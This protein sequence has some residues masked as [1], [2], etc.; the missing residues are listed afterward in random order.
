M[1]ATLILSSLG[2]LMALF[3]IQFGY[4]TIKREAT[5]VERAE[6]KAR[7]AILRAR[8]KKGGERMEQVPVGIGKAA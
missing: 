3:L 1:G 5:K 6:L 7:E 4:F 8:Q 2:L